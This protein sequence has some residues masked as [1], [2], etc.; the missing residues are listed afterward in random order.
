MNRRPP[1]KNSARGIWSIAYAAHNI[2]AKD[3]NML[4]YRVIGPN[5]FRTFDDA[6]KAYRRAKVI[7]GA[8][9]VTFYDLS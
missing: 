6:D 8:Q 4:K 2:T 3:S 7:R 1:H 9:V 5:Y